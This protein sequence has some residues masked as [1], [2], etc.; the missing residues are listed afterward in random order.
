MKTKNTIENID[1]GKAVEIIREDIGYSVGDCIDENMALASFL[2]EM[3]VPCVFEFGEAIYIPHNG[4]FRVAHRDYR[5]GRRND[6]DYPEPFHCWLNVDGKVLDISIGT[7]TNDL[8]DRYKKPYIYGGYHKGF[9]LGETFDCE[10]EIC[11]VD[12]PNNLHSYRKFR[13]PQR[14]NELIEGGELFGSNMTMYDDFGFDLAFIE[15]AQSYAAQYRK[16]VN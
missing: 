2:Y 9:Y 10:A 5:V 3:N 8:P 16:S 14:I 1:I 4:Y 11:S 6:P 7:W 13:S 15:I 12:L